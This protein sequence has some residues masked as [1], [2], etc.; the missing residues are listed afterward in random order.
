MKAYCWL[1]FVLAL[2]FVS[3]CASKPKR[4]EETT[5]VATHEI[6]PRATLPPQCENF[7]EKIH[8]CAKK[9]GH[10]ELGDL[11][12][13]IARCETGDKCIGHLDSSRRRYRGAFQFSP[14]TWRSLCGPVF[15]RLKVPVCRTS[16]SMY[17]ICCASMCTA[18][19]IAQGGIGNWPVCGERASR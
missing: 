14:R 8:S 19:V 2:F 9:A 13:G 11:M 16:K 10:E 12:C 4:H 1:P 5:P 17:D 7:C 6:A 18:E 3:G 15:T